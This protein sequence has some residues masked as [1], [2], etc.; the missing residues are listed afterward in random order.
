MV[1]LTVFP[2]IALP[3]HKLQAELRIA[4][5]PLGLAV[6]STGTRLL[7]SIGLTT[8]LALVALL[9]ATL[10]RLNSLRLP[11]RLQNLR[12]VIEGAGN[13]LTLAMVA[14]LPTSSVLQFR[15]RLRLLQR[16][17]VGWVLLGFIIAF[18]AAFIAAGDST[19]PTCGRTNTQATA[20]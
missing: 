19:A 2:L 15:K 9:A 3:S 12:V 6:A 8:A 1:K 4:L 20:A 10:R 17:N 7:P 16:G 14:G 13:P 18:L 11:G 5:A